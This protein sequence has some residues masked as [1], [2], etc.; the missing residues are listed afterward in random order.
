MI[1]SLHFCRI[2]MEYIRHIL[3]N[4]AI[5][6]SSLQLRANIFVGSANT[7]QASWGRQDFG[8]APM[9]NSILVL[10]L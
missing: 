6:A 3:E 2:S 4:I 10:K 9:S 7:E 8:E 5:L 1:A